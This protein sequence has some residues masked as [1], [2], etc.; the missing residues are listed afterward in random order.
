MGEYPRIEAPAREACAGSR[1]VLAELR[2]K[3]GT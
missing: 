3:V 1:N 2:S